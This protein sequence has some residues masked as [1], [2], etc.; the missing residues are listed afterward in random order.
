MIGIDNSLLEQA[1]FS[2]KLTKI[3]F[4]NITCKEC[5]QKGLTRKRDCDLLY[6]YQ[7]PCCKLMDKYI[8]RQNEKI[9][10]KIILSALKSFAGKMVSH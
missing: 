2:R 10:E 9:N 4:F 1:S 5:L 6:G 7:L 3:N 8:E